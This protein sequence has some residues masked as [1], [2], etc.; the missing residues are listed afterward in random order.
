MTEKQLRRFL[1]V[2]V[3]NLV[4]S[5][6]FMR[7]LV[8]SVE[9]GAFR[10]QT[11]W[12]GDLAWLSNSR[13]ISTVGSADSS[14]SITPGRRNVRARAEEERLSAGNA[15]EGSGEYSSVEE[16]MGFQGLGVGEE[17]CYLGH[18]WFDVQPQDVNID[19]DK[20]E[21]NEDAGAEDVDAGDVDSQDSDIWS[22]ARDTMDECDEFGFRG[23]PSSWE[24]SSPTRRARG[25]NEDL[26]ECVNSSHCAE[27][28]KYDDADEREAD[29]L[30]QPFV[31]PRSVILEADEGLLPGEGK[32]ERKETKAPEAC[33]AAPHRS[34]WG[35][36]AEVKGLT[37]LQCFLKQNTPQLVRDLMGVVNL[38]TINH[39]NICC[40]NTA[41]LILIF[42][43]RR[44]HL[45]EVSDA[46]GDKI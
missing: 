31:T 4:D 2:M 5:N 19:A 32:E 41:V 35:A 34:L 37:R 16:E 28:T 10:A 44:G 22:L 40:L 15:S 43:D 9:H 24:C 14:T 30:S 12:D 29:G 11:S 36:G 33:V 46:L 39:E 45:A 8:L 26:A 38:E 17:P 6:V 27:V 20:S 18:T 1:S 13:D 42:A 25:W 21:E 23:I 7:S 3:D